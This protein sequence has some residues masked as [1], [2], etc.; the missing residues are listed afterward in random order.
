MSDA[1]PRQQIL[2]VDDE[3]SN[4]RILVECLK[5]DY[6]LMVARGG[7]E[8]LEHAR[9]A[10]QLDLV[11]L[12]IQMPEMDGYEVCRSLKADSRLRTIPVIFITAMN[13]ERDEAQGFE[14]GAVDYI[15]KPFSTVIVK[16]RVDTHMELKRHRDHLEKLAEQRARQ[17]VHA[18]RLVQLGTLSAGIAHEISNPMTYISLSAT[19]LQKLFDGIVPS[20]QRAFENK[21]E[22]REEFRKFLEQGQNYLDSFTEGVSRI[23][24]I[25]GSMKK[26]ARRD[27]EEKKQ[28]DLEECIEDA[29]RICHSALKYN[30]EVEKTFDRNLPFIQANAQQLGQVFTNLFNNAAHAMEGRKDGELIIA[31]GPMD[32]T[33]VRV[34]VEDNGHGIPQDKME[35]IW[36]AFMTTKGPEKGTGLGLSISK[37]IIEDHGGRIFAEQRPEGGARF[38]IELPVSQSAA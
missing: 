14:L 27:T 10:E 32:D 20:V 35:T 8:A 22:D 1:L 16:A 36:E 18:E 19:M 4:I 15:T 9:N 29:L 37:G 7:F 26:F 34:T 2:I 31:A 28:T 17:L 3:P 5:P 11:L 6:E 23:Q 30:V 33:R 38:I 25:V 21:A 24:S 13:E 12:D